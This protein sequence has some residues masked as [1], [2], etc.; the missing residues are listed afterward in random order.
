[1]AFGVLFR[2]PYHQASQVRGTGSLCKANPGSLPVC[3][4]SAQ[5]LVWLHKTEAGLQLEA[6]GSKTQARFQV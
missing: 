6:G 1:M 5:N 3:R 2:V 4:P